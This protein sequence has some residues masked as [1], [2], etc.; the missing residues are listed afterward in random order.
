MVVKREEL[1]NCGVMKKRG[2]N[3]NRKI[4]EISCNKID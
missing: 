1:F 4:L 3:L 2:K